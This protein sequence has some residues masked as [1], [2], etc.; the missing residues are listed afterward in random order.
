MSLSPFIIIVR[1][2][3]FLATAR[4]GRDRQGRGDRNEFRFEFILNIPKQSAR[5]RRPS[6][7]V[8]MIRSFLAGHGLHMSPGRCAWNPACFR[9]DRCATASTWPCVR[10]ACMRPTTQA[11]PAMSHFISSIRL[12][13]D[14]IPQCLNTNAL[15]DESDRLRFGLGMSWRFPPRQRMMTRGSRSRLPTREAH[16]CEFAHLPHHRGPYLT[17]RA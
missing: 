7:S 17:R 9:Q 14:R 11:A 3:V 2:P 16:P 15:A 8:L 5:T 13:V 10:E 6:A 4:L 12:R 1:D